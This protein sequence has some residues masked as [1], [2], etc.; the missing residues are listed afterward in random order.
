MCGQCVC[1][2][3]SLY[4]GE[5]CEE[6]LVR[7]VILKW[8]C[9]ISV[10]CHDLVSILCKLRCVYLSCSVPVFTTTLNPWNRH[11]GVG[12]EEAR[13]IKVERPRKIACH[14]LWHTDLPT[15]FGLK[16]TMHDRYPRQR[17]QS[18]LKDYGLQLPHFQHH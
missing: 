12:S 18:G 6:C 4:F 16:Y 14:S 1:D 7:T 13:F 2:D 3:Y 11:K 17:L 15:Y 10:P 8:G 5:Y 9:S